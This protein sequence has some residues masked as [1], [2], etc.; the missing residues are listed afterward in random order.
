[1][2]GTITSFIPHYAPAAPTNEP[3]DYADLVIIDIAKAH[4][5]E[6]RAELALKLREALT[7]QGF[8]YTDRIFDVADVPFSLVSNEEK[9]T[10]AANIK[11]TGSYLGYKLRQ[12]WHIDAGVHDQV[13]HYNSKSVYFRIEPIGL[14]SLVNRDV[15][16]KQHPESLRPLLPE[17]EAF[18]KFNHIEILHTLLRLFALGLEL[19]EDTFVNQHNYSAADQSYVR[20]MKYY[21]R[22][23]DEEIKTKNIWLK[24]HTDFGTVTILWS[25]PVAALQILSPDGRWRWIR[26]IDNA[27]VV[28][29]GD[30]MEFLSGGFYK[31]TIHRVVQPPPDQRGFTRLGVFYFATTDDDIKLVPHAE[32]PVLQEHGITRRY[33]DAD[34][35]TMEVWS[36][37]RT[38]A[39]GQTELQKRESG[40][41]EEVINGVLVKHYN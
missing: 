25:Q 30:A 21:P 32:S 8:F 18:A 28:T 27:L 5:A 29:S 38:S 33:D 31:A 1:M 6:G 26:H 7:T 17:I 34:A 11:A 20:F 3:L 24:G 13:E 23:E 4:T 35:P 2:P 22:P 10:Y 14:Y 19:P 40:V 9:R 15:K 36:K 12:Y 41:E 37:S 16:K 39:Y